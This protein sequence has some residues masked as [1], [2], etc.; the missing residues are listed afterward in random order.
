MLHHLLRL[1]VDI[2]SKEATLIER[3]MRRIRQNLNLKVVTDEQIIVYATRLSSV[4]YPDPNASFICWAYDTQVRKRR[5]KECE[6]KKATCYQ[7]L[8]IEPTKINK[9]EKSRYS[10][11]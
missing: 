1:S 10:S 5:K 2:L 9:R 3:I 7:E 8:K 11:F 6:E 4:F